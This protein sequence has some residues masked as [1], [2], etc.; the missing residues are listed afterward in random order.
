MFLKILPV[1]SLFLC[2]FAYGGDEQELLLL[3]NGQIVEGKVKK[4]DSN[5][6]VT[7]ES[8]SRIFFA[9]ERVVLSCSNWNE[10]YWQKC[11]ML[12]AT[13]TRG[14]VQ[15]FK[16]CI[17]HDLVSAAQNQIDLLQHMKISATQ[18]HQLNQQLIDTRVA[19]ANKLK[20]RAEEL[21]RQADAIVSGKRDY[22]V[23]PAGYVE[24]TAAVLTSTEIQQSSTSS[25]KAKAQQSG[26]A[27]P[28]NAIDPF[29]PEVFNRQY[30]RNK[31]ADEPE[32]TADVK[33]GDQ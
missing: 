30:V 20:N 24:G 13:D 23:K 15:L 18:L 21:V 3:T 22:N 26:N 5:Y 7:K 14:H 29:D 17:K 19:L 1:I 27:N 16:W 12:Q 25:H 31:P 8:G 2:T 33:S 32:P 6:I 10:M 9:A 4:R 28:S 11:A